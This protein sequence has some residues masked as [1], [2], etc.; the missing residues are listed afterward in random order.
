MKVNGNTVLITGGTTGIGLALAESFLKLG[1]E[2]VIC[3]R[4]EKDYLSTKE[5]F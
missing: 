2:A 1:N 4:R 5:S 3:G